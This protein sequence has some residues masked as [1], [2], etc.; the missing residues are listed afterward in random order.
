[1]PKRHSSTP[2]FTAEYLRSIL[3]YDPKTGVFTWRRR[4]DFPTLACKNNW[5]VRFAGKRAGGTDRTGARHSQHSLYYRVAIKNKKYWLHR[6]AWLHHHGDW[7]PDEIDHIDGDGL[8]N[9]IA[10]LRLAT[11]SENCANTKRGRN[12]TV[13]LKGVYRHK[14]GRYGAQITKDRRHIHLGLFDS[15]EEAHTAYIEAAQ[16]LFGGYARTD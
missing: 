16:N 1:M 5:N 14:C 7:P 8:N 13:G 4:D 2:P 11:R 12:N 3:D 6:L 9:A 10:N 15:P